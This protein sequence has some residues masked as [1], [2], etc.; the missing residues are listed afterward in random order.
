M[1][2]TLLQAAESDIAWT[3]AIVA[4][5]GI[6]MVTVILAV[7]IWQ[8]FGTWRARMSVAREEAYRKLAEENL[9]AQTRLS[10]QQQRIADDLTS[11]NE[12]VANIE[13]LLKEVG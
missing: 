8:V 12:R 7:S 13:K 1:F 2:P 5:G 3:E 10:V 9:S 4:V 6:F 11:I